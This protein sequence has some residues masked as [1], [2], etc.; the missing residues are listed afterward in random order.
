M[1]PLREP[2]P[3]QPPS[4]LWLAAAISSGA[5]AVLGL[6]FYFWFTSAVNRCVNTLTEIS[7]QCSG[8]ETGRDISG[9]IGLLLVAICFFTA[10]MYARRPR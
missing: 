6:A 1:P 4:E 9:V 2:A 3:P 7:G 8:I 10:A 5:L